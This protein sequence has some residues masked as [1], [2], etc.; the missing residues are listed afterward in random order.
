[1]DE[2]GA[3]ALD[4]MARAKTGESRYDSIPALLTSFVH[5]K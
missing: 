1:M 5:V 2:E 3:V 4:Q